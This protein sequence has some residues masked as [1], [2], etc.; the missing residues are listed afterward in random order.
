MKDAQKDDQIPG[1]RDEEAGR[2]RRRAD[3]ASYQGD[4]PDAD[5]PRQYSR[6]EPDQDASSLVT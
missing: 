5:I 1:A 2:N 4:L 3:Q 6:D